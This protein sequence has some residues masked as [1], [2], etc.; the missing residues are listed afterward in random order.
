MDRVPLVGTTL[1]IGRLLMTKG[2]APFSIVKTSEFEASAV[3]ALPANSQRIGFDSKASTRPGKARIMLAI[4]RIAE[5]RPDDA[6]AAS[7]FTRR[8]VDIPDSASDQ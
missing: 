3:T 1:S 8:A 7:R 4:K 6:I 5:R 2:F